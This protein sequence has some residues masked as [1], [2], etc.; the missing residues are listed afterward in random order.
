M[1][2]RCVLQHVASR[3]ARWSRRR[4]PPRSK[5]PRPLLQQVAAPAVH[6]R[7]DARGVGEHA[8]WSERAAGEGEGRERFERLCKRDGEGPRREERLRRCEEV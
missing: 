7:K 3:A 4:V 1:L 5:E 8:G 6:E 2:L